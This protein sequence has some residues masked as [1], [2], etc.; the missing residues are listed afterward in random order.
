VKFRDH[1]IPANTAIFLSVYGIHH[2]PKNWEDPEKFIPERFE[3][4]KHDHF[5]WL[6]FGA[7]NRA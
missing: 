7:G 5:A 1:V 6:G 4:E 3:N 2:S